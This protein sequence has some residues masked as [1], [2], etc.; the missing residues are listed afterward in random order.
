MQSRDPNVRI[1]PQVGP[2]DELSLRVSTAVLTKTTFRH[3][4]SGEHM[5]VLERKAVAEI[6]SSGMKEKL[7]AQPLGG[8]SRLVDPSAL[9]RVV[10]QFNY[11]SAESKSEGDFRIQIRPEDWPRVRDFCVKHF[12]VP[13][14]GVIEANPE[15]EL[16]EELGDSLDIEVDPT[17]YCTR[18]LGI[19][20]RGATSTDR[21]GVSGQQTVRAFNIYHVEIT[22]PT[23]IT[24]ILENSSLVSDQSLN[25]DAREKATTSGKKGKS[26][27]LLALPISHVVEAF[28]SRDLSGEW[29]T[30]TVEGHTIADNVPA[31]FC[32]ELPEVVVTR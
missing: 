28:V 30:V 32:E 25:R 18:N 29:P 5:L 2:T 1:E 19:V 7:Q 22:E 23:L 14:T 27:A 10:G 3:P 21:V 17:G 9:G 24:K 12:M 15:R 26:T 31:I 8:A 6:T 4:E 20:L 11:D 16:A 13:S